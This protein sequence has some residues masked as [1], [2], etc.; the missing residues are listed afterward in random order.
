MKAGTGYFEFPYSAL[1]LK[2]LRVIDCIVRDILEMDDVDVDCGDFEMYGTRSANNYPRDIFSISFGEGRIKNY[3]GKD[4][5][6]DYAKR[7]LGKVGE[8]I[9]CKNTAIEVAPGKGDK[10]FLRVKCAFGAFN[11]MLCT[12]EQDLS[13]YYAIALAL[14]LMCERDPIL[15]EGVEHMFE[16]QR[17]QNPSISMLKKHVE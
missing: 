5:S 17:K 6:R 14:A 1:Y 8:N 13:V 9:K 4:N 12:K 11:A 2:E 10:K 7:I 3:V 15:Q 16:S